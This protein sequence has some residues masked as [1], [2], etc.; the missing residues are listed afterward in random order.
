MPFPDLHG[1][2]AAYSRASE[3]ESGGNE[4]GV[5]ERNEEGAF[6]FAFAFRPSVECSSGPVASITFTISCSNLTRYS[7]LGDVP[8]RSRNVPRTPMLLGLR[9]KGVPA[10]LRKNIRTRWR[11]PPSQN[12]RGPPPECFRLF[13]RH[14][15]G[16]TEPSH[17]GLVVGPV[18]VRISRYKSH[19]Y[20]LFGPIIVPSIP[21]K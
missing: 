19:I 3:K 6:A 1:N 10:Q 2:E 16:S 12:Y 9:G 14:L 5:E 13:P 15:T 18:P 8:V 17:L 11:R 20:R 7:I 4:Q 21:S